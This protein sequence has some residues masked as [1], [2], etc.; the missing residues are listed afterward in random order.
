MMEEI[1][2][3]SDPETVPSSAFG[4]FRGNLPLSSGTTSASAPSTKNSNSYHNSNDTEQPPRIQFPRTSGSMNNR[5]TF[6]RDTIQSQIVP[7][8]EQLQKR[9]QQAGRV[10]KNFGNRLQKINLGKLIDQ[11]EQDQGLANS[12]ESLNCRMKEEVERQ[13]VR[14]EAE[15]LTLKV[16][17]DHLDGFLIAHPLRGTY[18]EWISDLHPENANQGKLFVDIQQIDER[19]YVLESDHRKLWNAAIEKQH[20]ENE[21]KAD[22]NNGNDNHQQQVS[23]AHR[24]VEARSQI[25]G[26]TPGANININAHPQNAKSG[27]C[28][29]SM[30]GGGDGNGNG[31][32]DNHSVRMPTNSNAVIDLLSGSIDFHSSNNGRAASSAVPT[33]NTVT[34]EIDFF[35]PTTTTIAP[36]GA[37]DSDGNN[38]FKT[39]QGVAK[40]EDPFQDLINF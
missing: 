4:E 2:F 35:A 39:A 34:E 30:G 15:E 21:E 29:H 5:A 36:A 12:L 9:K 26:K 27:Y 16:I 11:M 32:G 6:L 23:Y 13:E 38:G 40:E 10:L 3:S 25:W 19:F 14:R 18:E 33:N 1:D 20:K 24:L 37:G 28:N 17:T 8:S 22:T 7:T 31:N